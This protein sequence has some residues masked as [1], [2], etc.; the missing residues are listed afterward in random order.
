MIVSFFKDVGAARFPIATGLRVMMLPF[1]LQDV[2][3]SLPRHCRQYSR[4]VESMLEHAHVGAGVGYLTI[5]EAEVRD[6]ETHRRPGIHVDGCGVWGRGGGYAYDGMLVA[7]SDVGCQA[8][9]GVYD[10]EPGYDGDCEHLRR[11]IGEPTV[12]QAGRVYSCGGMTVHEALPMKATTRRQFVRISLP[13]D[14]D[15]HDG[16]TRNP[17]GIEPTGRVA[18]RRV[19][20]MS[21]R[22]A[23]V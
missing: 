5:D 1:L 10:S 4:L 11:E 6:G 12:M 20:Q 14:R 18:A 15:W 17:E 8:W 7:A 16:Y 19:R 13:N 23:S 22:S 21:Y 3:R 9:T 2:N